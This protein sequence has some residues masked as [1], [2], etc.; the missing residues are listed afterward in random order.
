QHLGDTSFRCARL[1]ISV[2]CRRVLYVAVATPQPSAPYL[3]RIT[4]DRLSLGPR[5]GARRQP[6]THRQKKL[7][8]A[9]ACAE[10]PHRQMSRPNYLRLAK[11]VNVSIWILALALFAVHLFVVLG[12]SI[13][14][15]FWDDWDALRPGHLD[16]ALSWKWLIA[17]HNAH[18]NVFTN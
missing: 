12:Y 3:S 2:L 17:F 4:G 11:R 6:L 10:I 7:R 13:N 16:R 1:S 8:P 18:R 9:V 14:L 15:P 5:R